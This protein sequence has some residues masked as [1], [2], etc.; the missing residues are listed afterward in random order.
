MYTKK[1]ER[2]KMDTIYVDVISDLKDQWIM[3]KMIMITDGEIDSV[4]TL[5]GVNGWVEKWGQGWTDD[6]HD[7]YKKFVC[8]MDEGWKW[9]LLEE[10]IYYA[11]NEEYTYI[12]I[13]ARHNYKAYFSTDYDEKLLKKIKENA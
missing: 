12:I 4:S 3:E 6:T 10:Q 7:E 11:I 13:D 2:I 8:E 1:K 5:D 9:E